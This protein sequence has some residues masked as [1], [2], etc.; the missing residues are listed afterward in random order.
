MGE[1]YAALGL[2][3]LP[4]LQ[5][6]VQ[7]R[8]RSVQLYKKLLGNIFGVSFQHIPR[9]YQSSNKDFSIFIDP[10]PFG[11]NRDQLAAAL[12][13]ENIDTRNY[14]YPPIHQLA[15]YRE[16][17]TGGLTQTERKSERVLSLPIYNNM[18]D[19]I[20]GGICEAIRRIRMNARAVVDA[21]G[22]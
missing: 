11:M 5:D 15:P 19:R 22:K 2:A 20:V 7:S 21:L 18:D 9:G 3:Q 4:S 16:F 6:F 8:E 10:K 1:P 13:F 12:K 17:Y 14:F